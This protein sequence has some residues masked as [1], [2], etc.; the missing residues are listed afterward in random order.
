ML[1]VLEFDA[2]LYEAASISVQQNHEAAVLGFAEDTHKKWLDRR[3]MFI[4]NPDDTSRKQPRE[5]VLEW[6]LSFHA[7]VLD[8]L[9]AYEKTFVQTVLRGASLE[10]SNS[11]LSILNQGADTSR[12]YMKL[13]AEFLGIPVG[14]RLV[15]L[16]KVDRYV[17]NAITAIDPFEVS[18]SRANGGRESVFSESGTNEGMESDEDGDY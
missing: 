15:R 1:Q 12:V 6:L 9:Q 3:Y 14:S 8:W 5:I 18:E 17:K 16:W 7:R 11:T 10:N 13:I 2:A 4:S